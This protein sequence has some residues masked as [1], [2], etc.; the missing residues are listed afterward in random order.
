VLRLSGSVVYASIAF[1]ASSLAVLVFYD[2]KTGSQLRARA[3]A[4]VPM[5]PR[6]NFERLRSL[7]ILAAPLAPAAT[8]SSLNSN[9]PRYVVQGYLGEK[10]LGIFAAITYVLVGAGSIALALGQGISP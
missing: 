7:A 4:S 1:A 8:L 3:V 2:S 9:I 10:D 5:R 6:W